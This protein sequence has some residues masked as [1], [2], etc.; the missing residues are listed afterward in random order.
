MNSRGLLINIKKFLSDKGTG[1]LLYLLAL[2]VF[3]LKLFIESSTFAIPHFFDLLAKAL[4]LLFILIKLVFYDS[5]K[6]HELY[7]CLFFLALGVVIFLCAGKLEI[8]YYFYALAGAKD[9]DFR[10]ILK[11]Y[12]WLSLFFLFMAY[13]ASA[14]MLIVNLQYRKSEAF[15]GVRNSFGIG[16]PTDFAAHVFFMFV[17]GALIYRRKLKIAHFLLA[18]LF[19]LIIFLF[20]YTKL[21]CICMLFGCIIFAILSFRDNIAGIKDKYRKYGPDPAAAV[22]L[23][24]PLAAAFMGGITFCYSE[25]SSFLVK[26]DEFLTHRLRLG[27]MGFENF[28]IKPFGS[29]IN[30]IGGGGNVIFSADYNFVD[31]SYLYVL[32]CF[33]FVTLAVLFAAYALCC[34][35]LRRDYW[36]LAA[37]VLLVINCMVAHHLTDLSFNPF[38]LALF[39][40]VSQDKGDKEGNP[41]AED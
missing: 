16:F 36:Y 29:Q 25:D 21:D 13:L 11:V 3:L 14:V 41:E 24:M 34:M 7:G 2:S 27:K 12:F 31:C 23:F 40:S 15:F 4:F 39:A 28:P 37:I 20:C 38:A 10:R 32:F 33:G 19:D 8:F 5:F 6:I 35:R 30:M 26:F 1:E 17:C 9:V 22:A 18:S